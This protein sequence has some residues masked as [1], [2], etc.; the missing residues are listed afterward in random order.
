M[1]SI[2][3]MH[4]LTICISHLLPKINDVINNNVC[5][6]A[7]IYI[8]MCVHV[9]MYV[10]MYV[11]Y[12]YISTQ[13]ETQIDWQRWRRTEIDREP[14]WKHE[15]RRDLLLGNDSCTRQCWATDKGSWELVILFQPEGHKDTGSAPKEL[16]MQSFQ[17][18]SPGKLPL[19]QG[20]KDL[21]SKTSIVWVI[22]IHN[23]KSDP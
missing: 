16:K 10:H 9:C 1:V 8:Y 18:Q 13:Q 6:Y 19:T 7:C 15:G 12:T 14:I 3:S 21:F 11:W 23:V 5:I 4:F 22:L 17:K 2:W 20:A